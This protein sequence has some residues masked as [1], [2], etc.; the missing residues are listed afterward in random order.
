MKNI[1]I[2]EVYGCRVVVTIIGNYIKKHIND[3][4]IINLNIDK[5]PEIWRS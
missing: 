5:M 3:K 4:S 1:E 2:N